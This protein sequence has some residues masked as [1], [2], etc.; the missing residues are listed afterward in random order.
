MSF[1]YDAELPTSLDRVRFTIGDTISTDPQLQNEEIQAM[2]DEHGDVVRATAIACVDALI[3]RYARYVDKWVG[4]LKILASQRY[5]Q[6]KELRE[7]L[8]MA[9]DNVALSGVPTAGGVYVAE[10]EQARNN[11]QLVQGAF[12]IGMHDYE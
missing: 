1:S 5:R 12:R 2:L 3:A 6:Y 7:R 11:T 10:K 4:D 9:V 8:L